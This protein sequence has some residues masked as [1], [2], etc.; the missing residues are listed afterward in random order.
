[1]S[2][3]HCARQS[4][5]P[6]T[7]A[8]PM[9]TKQI[10]DIMLNIRNGFAAPD[11]AID[12]EKAID[13]CT[14]LKDASCEILTRAEFDAIP[15]SNPSEALWDR[16]TKTIYIPEDLEK[17][18]GVRRKRYT[19]AHELSHMILGHK[20]PALLYGRG[21]PSR[22]EDIPLY[23]DPEWQADKGASF[24][25]MTAAGVETKCLFTAR[26]VSEMFNVSEESAGYFLNDL[27]RIS[28]RA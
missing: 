4:F 18:V 11:E 24:L 19:I 7:E 10:H 23:R 12:I 27:R 15:N 13:Y 6:G 2:F 3:N 25:L 20:P 9:S 26:E 16:V 28:R 17:V 8:D 5:I 14:W 1:M 21:T 22:R